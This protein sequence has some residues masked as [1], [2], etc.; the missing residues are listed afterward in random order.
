ML[1]LGFLLTCVRHRPLQTPLP[2][3][4]PQPR[5]LTCFSSRR[6]E[7]SFWSP[8]RGRRLHRWRCGSLPSALPM[9]Y[10]TPH[11]SLH[12]WVKSEVFRQGLRFAPCQCFQDQRLHSHPTFHIMTTSRSLQL[13][14]YTKL[15][16]VFMSVSICFHY[17]ARSLLFLQFTR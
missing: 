5:S 6:R 3:A 2:C 13:P 7:P 15:C 11:P 1:A 9:L 8:G 17:P 14:K 4:S 10:S 16:H 12:L